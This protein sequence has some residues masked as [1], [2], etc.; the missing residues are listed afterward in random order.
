MAVVGRF[1]G[2]QCPQQQ[3]DHGGI[4]DVLLVMAVQVER[5]DDGRVVAIEV[6]I[7]VIVLFVGC[8]GEDGGCYRDAVAVE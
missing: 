6:V 7:E 2:I 3:F 4:D 1:D 8:I 5:Q